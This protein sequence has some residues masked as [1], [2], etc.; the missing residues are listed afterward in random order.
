MPSPLTVSRRL[1]LAAL[2]TTA[3]ALPVAAHPAPFPHSHDP[4]HPPTRPMQPPPRS[5]P[6]P[7]YV[8]APAEAPRPWRRPIFYLGLGGIG[9]AVTCDPDSSLSCAMD[10]GA[11]LELFLGWRVG[12]VLGIDLDWT[13]SFHDAPNSFDPGMRAALTTV[14]A[15]FRFFLVPSSYRIEPYALFGIGGTALSRGNGEL[16]TLTGASIDAGAG[17]DINLSR[18]LTLG[19]KGSWRGAWL[20]DRETFAFDII[21]KTFLSTLTAGAHVRVNF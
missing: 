14:A 15:N 5:A 8:E 16:P 20:A 3:L 11:G 2:I 9:S 7:V 4:Q 6:A 12:G 13:T 1:A 18:R 21:E 10:G 17:I 19:I